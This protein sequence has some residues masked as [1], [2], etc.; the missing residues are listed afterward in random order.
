MK[1]ASNNDKMR[2]KREGTRVDDREEKEEIE[3]CLINSDRDEL[4]Q[5]KV[6]SVILF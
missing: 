3:K 2:L 5:A 1:D 6:N 4:T